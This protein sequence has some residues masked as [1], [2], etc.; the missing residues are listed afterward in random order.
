MKESGVHLEVTN[1][2]ITDLNDSEEDVTELVAWIVENLGRDTPVHFSRYFPHREM[3]APPTPVH[4]ML[5]AKEIAE[6]ELYYVYMG[7]V[8]GVGGTDTACP[9]CAN[10]LVE[11]AGYST[12]VI[13]ITADGKCGDCG[14]AVDIVL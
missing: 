13:G 8:G 10:L 11:R 9:E 6:R 14:R 7:N 2:L 3:D 1:L 5:R 12:R 4:R